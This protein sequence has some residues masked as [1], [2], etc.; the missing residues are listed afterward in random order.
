MLL[1]QEAANFVDLQNVNKQVKL[2]TFLAYEE[3]T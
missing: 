1:Y 3:Q 2:K